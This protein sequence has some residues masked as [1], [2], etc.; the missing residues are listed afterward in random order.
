MRPH[1]PVRTH[2]RTRDRLGPDM[3]VNERNQ[4]RSVMAKRR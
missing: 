3:S 4:S 1:Y 2:P